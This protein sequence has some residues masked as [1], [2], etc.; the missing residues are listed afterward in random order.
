IPLSIVTAVLVMYAGGQTL[1]TMTL[2]GFA[3]AVGIL[4]DNGT[5]VIENIERHVG[6]GE[7]LETAI[8]RGAGEVGVPTFLSTLCICIVFVPV[9]LLEG[10]AKY[11][12]SPLS[13]S[14]CVSLVAS[15]ALS[16]TLV[17]V[18]FKYLMQPSTARLVAWHHV[19]RGGRWKTPFVAIHRGFERGFN[20]FRETYRNS[21]AWA[22][23]HPVLTIAF[24]ALLILGSLLLFPQLG[25]DFFPQVDAGQVRLHV[26]APPG[27]RIEQTQE[28]FAEAEAAIRQI[29][30]SDQVDVILDNIGLPYSGINIALSDSAT[31]GPMDG[32]ILVSLRAKH[33]PTS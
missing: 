11:L 14:V 1:N 30:G 13:I 6:L 17:P 16:F 29:V 10:T 19:P 5:V 23:S 9:F 12:F 33:T 26:R 18:L 2:G 21:L 8:V 22:V 3:L 7:P 15:L 31:V 4:V 24:F 32:E 20:S 27:T 25:R 28:Y